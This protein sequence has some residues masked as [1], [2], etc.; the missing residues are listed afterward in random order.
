VL[1]PTLIENIRALR[2]DAQFTLI[3]EKDATFQHLIDNNF[4][5]KYSAILITVMP[6]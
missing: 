3:V 2:S 4:T 1:V 6:H 5:Q